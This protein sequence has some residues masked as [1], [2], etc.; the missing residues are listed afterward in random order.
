MS[1]IGPTGTAVDQQTCDLSLPNPATVFLCSR[2][3]R[4]EQRLECCCE[5]GFS[6]TDLAGVLRSHDKRLPVL[7]GN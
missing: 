1:A 4:S 5:P 2:L 7:E 6:L 3:Y